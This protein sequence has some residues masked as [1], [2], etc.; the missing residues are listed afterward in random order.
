[1]ASKSKRARRV[2]KRNLSKTLL[3][4]ACIVFLIKLAIIFRIE[5]VNSG[6]GDQVYFIDGAWL[7]ADGE[8]YLKGYFGLIRD[9]FFSREEILYKWPAGYP[10]LIYFLSFFGQS[11]VLTTLSI[12]QS[13]LFSYAAYFFA[14]ELLKTRLKNFSLLTLLIIICNPTL[15]LSSIVIGYESLVASGLLI[16]LGLVTRSFSGSNNGKDTHNLIISSL[17]LGYV[18]MLQPRYLATGLL[19]LLIWFSYKKRDLLSAGI[20]IISLT[21]MLCFPTTLIFRNYYSTGQNIISANL[22]VTMNIGAGSGATGGFQTKGNYGVPCELS[23]TEVQKDNQKVKCVLKWYISN[24][25]ESSRLFVN[26]S[27]YFWSPWFG[28]LENGTMGRNPWL[29]IHPI[30]QSIS[31]RE[32]LEAVYGNFGKFISWA[33]LMGGICLMLY[34]FRI[35][36]GARYVERQIA[37]LTLIIISV[38]WFISLLTIGDHRF[39]IPIMGLSLFLQAVGLKTLF[40]GGKAPMVDGPALR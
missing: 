2:T 1:M 21:L 31:D 29:T 7:G 15:S 17:I 18:S 14:N 38:N 9:G 13:A 19:I 30:K 26:K 32:T 36:W 4:W 23:G 37:L 35:L 24:P 16:S 3:Y 10:L 39:R 22:G 5:G 28:P 25:K 8:N 27:I 34:G 11:W 33:W 12:V 40:S 6:S 20:S